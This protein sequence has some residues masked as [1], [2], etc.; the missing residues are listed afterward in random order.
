MVVSMIIKGAT[1][2]GDGL[3]DV[4]IVTGRIVQ[5]GSQLASEGDFVL[6]AM[7]GQLLPGLHDHHIHLAACARQN[8]S[9]YCGPPFVQNDKELQ[10]ALC[11][12]GG[13]FIRGTGYD[14]S[15][16]G[17]LDR[18][19]LDTLCPDRPVRI[20]HRSGRMWFL[21][22]LALECALS[23]G[24]LVP[25]GLEKQNGDWTGRLFDGDDWLRH[26]LGGQFPDLSHV[27]QELA[28]YGVT[29]I[30]DL[31]PKNDDSTAVHIAKQAA[32]SQFLQRVVMGGTLN[33]AKDLPGGIQRGPAKLHLHEADFPPCESVEKFIRLS[34][35][36]GRPVAIHCV[37]EVELVFALAALRQASVLTGDRIEHASVSTP[38]L[39]RQIADLN[40]IVV[41]QPHFIHDRGDSY[42]HEIAVA[43]HEHLYRLRS[44]LD[45]GARL[46]GGSD[47]PYGSIDP[48]TAMAAAVSRNRGTRSPH[49]R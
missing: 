19:Q 39:V 36:Q 14:E 7:G 32:T 38:E 2:N 44:F 35:D 48:W 31:S 46:C 42:R 13:A 40:L 12:P 1:I 6:D 21:N 26:A 28:R 3:A 8:D 4:R 20:Q 27:S 17:M 10:Q 37:T 34:H 33:L 43:D 25:S 41:A 15:I 24:K 45:E 9:V 22:T 5:I 30:T 29:G 16:A 18:R 23:S 49:S 11:L 47:G